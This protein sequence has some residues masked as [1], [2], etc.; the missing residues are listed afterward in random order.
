MKKIILAFMFQ[1][2]ILCICLGQKTELKIDSG[3][4]EVNTGRLYYE[5]AGTGENVVLLHDGMVSHE[6]WDYQFP[7]LAKYYKVVRY[8]RRGYGK[9]SDP[10]APY[11][12]IED[13]NELFLKLGIEKAVLFGM[14]S[15]GGLVIDFTLKYP[16]KVKSVILVGAV[17]GGY[18]YTSHMTYRGGHLKSPADMADPVKAASYFVWEDPYEIYSENIAA[19]Q[20]VAEILQRNIHRPFNS[21]F[22]KPPERIAARFLNEIKVPALILVGEY[23]IP[24]VHSHAGVIQFGIP[25]ARREVIL[26][27]GH[28]IPVEQPGEFNIAVFR[29]IRRNEFF[30]CLNSG[31]IEA[32]EKY[33]NNTFNSEPQVPLF[34]EAE[35]NQLGYR[36]LQEG[37]IK[38]SIRLFTLN[39]VSYPDSWNVYD[40]LGEALLKDGNG[41]QA[42]K[43][44]S[45]SLK[46]NPE[47]ENALQVLKSLGKGQ[48]PD[49][50]QI[51]AQVERIGEMELWPGFDIKAVPVMVFDSTDTWLF[52]SDVTP[53]GFLPVPGKAGVMSFKGQHALVRGNSIVR[54]GEKFIAT[55]ALTSHGK[56]TGEKYTVTDLAG[57]IVHEQFHVFQRLRHPTWRQNDGV[58]LFYP[59]E[60]NESVLLRK[61]EKESFR[62]AV[63]SVARNDMAGWAFTAL[64]YRNKRLALIPGVFSDYEKELQRTEGLSDYIERRARSLDPLNASDITNGIAPAGVRD[65]GYVEG[66]W[67]AMIL[68]K[69]NP[70]WKTL[71]EE[72]DSLYLEDILS[73]KL[74][75]MQ[76]SAVQFSMKEIDSLRM[77]SDDAFNRW[78]LKKAE[79]ISDY[80]VQPGFNLRI[81]ASGSPFSIRIFEPLEIE[82]TDDGGVYHRLIF[83][84]ANQRGSIRIMNHPCVTYFNNS[85]QLSTISLTGLRMRP[86]IDHET[87]KCTLKYDE[88]DIALDFSEVTESGEGIRLRL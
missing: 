79:E 36:Y 60:T 52:F 67:I 38:E 20:K 75:E 35:M 31:G 61:L 53:E 16:E 13:L 37:K 64:E 54:L 6:I 47:N 23:D 19:K 10:E 29:F 28:L 26:N 51:I 74:S 17:V 71:L 58:L 40:S 43:N 7:L 65:L 70:D 32:A 41:S 81:D 62:R 72:N 83:S 39:V 24:D 76:S 55:S 69:L 50:F 77:A 27:S 42:E 85:F 5:I 44:Y 11:S 33:F 21:Q 3:F 1:N 8:D 22:N 4:I 68:D 9:S 45:K 56:R 63:T 87:K 73:G 2:L 18:G 34:G 78:Q 86:V 46:L 12:N 66:R 80:L 84:G 15:G 88:I 82:M 14:S 49:V 59:R 25:G 57:I 48:S 30:N